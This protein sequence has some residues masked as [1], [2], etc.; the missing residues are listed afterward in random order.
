MVGT[1]PIR[2]PSRRGCG[3]RLAQLGSWCE[4]SSCRYLPDR[5]PCDGL[6]T[7]GQRV[8]DREQLRRR[9]GEGGAMALD[10]GRVAAG[11]RARQRLGSALCPVGGGAQDQR[12]EQLA[13]VARP[14]SARRSS[15]A[16][17]SSAT[18]RLEAIAAAAW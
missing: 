6:G 14:R 4:P 13:R 11:D 5:F 8:V 1:R 2:L 12:G 18:S 10:G 9:L 17:S 15:A 3:Q 16:D 7:L